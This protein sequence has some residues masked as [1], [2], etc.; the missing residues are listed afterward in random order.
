MPRGKPIVISLKGKTFGRWTALTK[1][2]GKWKCRCSCGTIRTVYTYT[3]V[4]GRSKS[5]GCLNIDQVSIRSK[6]NKFALTHGFFSKNKRL[7]TIWYHMIDRCENQ[8]DRGYKYYGGRGI[9]VCKRWHDER[10]FFIWARKNGY[11]PTL[12]LE[13]VNNNGIY[14]PDN[15]T[16]IPKGAQSR[17]RNSIGYLGR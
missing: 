9:K 2:G 11:K 8:N 6:G 5:C 13:R 1:Y 12:T 17:N 16:W 15:C 3:L 4:N 14:S 7:H 10:T